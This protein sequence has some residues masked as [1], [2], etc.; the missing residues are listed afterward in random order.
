MLRADHAID[1]IF[2]WIGLALLQLSYYVYST[3][4]PFLLHEYGNRA[5]RDTN[6]P[7][8][9]L[10]IDP[11]CAVA[12]LALEED[13]LDLGTK[14]VTPGSTLG[15]P[16]YGALPGIVAAAGDADDPAHEPDGVLG[17]VGGDE[18]VFRPHV[19]VA[20]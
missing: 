6:A 12:L 4:D 8:P 3:S 17:R 20:H 9:E 11:W 1:K 19:F 16:G 5:L 10:S 13:R 2:E 15:P 18:R 14:T 7:R